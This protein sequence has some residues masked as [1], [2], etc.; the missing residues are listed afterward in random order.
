MMEWKGLVAGLGLGVCE[1]AGC[2]GLSHAASAK[3]RLRE[4]PQKTY[5]LT[6][7]EGCLDTHV[8]SDPCLKRVSFGTM[9]CDSTMGGV[10]D[11]KKQLSLYASE[12]A[13]RAF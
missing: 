1:A 6:Q 13:D 11:L 3:A 2:F 9:K 5:P 7:E 12:A 10:S 4:G 8:V